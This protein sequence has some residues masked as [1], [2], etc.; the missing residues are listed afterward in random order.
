ML[1]L[2]SL[3]PY[4]ETLFTFAHG[5]RAV[6]AQRTPRQNSLLAALPAEDYERLLPRLEPVPLPPGSTV[7]R[8]GNREKYL[9]FL[10]AGVVSRFQAMASG[11]ATE[12]ALTGREGVIGVATFLGGES[13]LSQAVVVSAGNAQT[14]R[15]RQSRK[16]PGFQEPQPSARQRA[17]LVENEMGR[18]REG[19]ERV[20]ARDQQPQTREMSG[21]GR[22][23]RGYS[24]YGLGL[25]LVALPAYALSEPVFGRHF[26]LYEGFDRFGNER[27]G[28][29]SNDR[30][31]RSFLSGAHQ[32]ER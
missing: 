20:P 19:F 5:R 27:T 29:A 26:G 22:D 7:H 16:R 8:A 24:K 2:H 30:S 4:A 32:H 28:A 12:F 10:S 18:V 31:D 3:Q 6:G 15:G 13:I 14:L 25:S 11:T 17:G 21:R 1:E 23:G 9:Y